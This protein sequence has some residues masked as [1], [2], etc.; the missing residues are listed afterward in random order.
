MKFVKKLEMFFVLAILVALA[1]IVYNWYQTNNFKNKPLSYAIQKEIKDRQNEVLSLIHEKYGVYTDISLIVSD[2]F[3][4][5]LYGLTRYRDGK[6]TIYLN[7]KRFRESERYMI[8]E[9]IPHEY[10]HALV[11]ALK[12]RAS[13][14][15]HTDLWQNICLQLD[16]KTCTRYVDNEEI[17]SQKMT[18]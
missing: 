16:G 1:Y 10:A 11:F 15:G 3:S 8:E 12:E 6:I 18:F 7:K 9:V 4:S 5:Q 2:E 13:K 17:V 14:D